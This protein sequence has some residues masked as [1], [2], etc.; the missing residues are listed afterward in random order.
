MPV[1]R[2][3][4]QTDSSSKPPYLQ[5]TDRQAERGREGERKRK[6]KRKRKE[7]PSLLKKKVKPMFCSSFPEKGKGS[8]FRAPERGYPEATQLPF[9]CDKAITLQGWTDSYYTDYGDI[10][11]SMRVKTYYRV[12]VTCDLL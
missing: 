8:L 7:S 1:L 11:A 12:C 5:E 4:E 6:W 2:R 3:M 10:Q 9:L